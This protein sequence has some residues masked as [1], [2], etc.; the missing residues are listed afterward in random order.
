MTMVLFPDILKQ[1]RRQDISWRGQMGFTAWAAVHVGSLRSKNCRCFPGFWD[2]TSQTAFAPNGRQLQFNCMQF[3]LRFSKIAQQQETIVSSKRRPG[4]E[5]NP[6]TGL[7]SWLRSTPWMK[8]SGVATDDSSNFLIW[9]FLISF[10]ALR[11]SI[12]ASTR[13][14]FQPYAA[15]LSL[16]SLQGIK[17]K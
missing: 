6:R 2:I 11:L 9:S 12:R 16:Y 3:T 17:R 5:R 14:T 13:K 15:I 7:V 10:A 8:Q 4:G 1:L